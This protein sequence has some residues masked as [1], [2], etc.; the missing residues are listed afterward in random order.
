MWMRFVSIVAAAAI[1]ATAAACSSSDSKKGAPTPSTPAGSATAVPDAIDARIDAILSDGGP[2]FG[3]FSRAELRKMMTVETDTPFY[4]VN[5]IKFRQFA[6]YADGHD[7]TVSGR[8]ANNR[9][10]VLPILLEIGARPVFVADVEQELIG[11]STKWDQVAIVRYPSRKAF[12]ALLERA[13]FH[14][15]S[16][17]KDAAVEKSTVLV[18]SMRDLPPLPPVDPAT[19]SNPATAD[20]KAFTMVHLMRFKDRATDGSGKETQLSGRDAIANYEQSV[21]AAAL[22]LGIRPAAILVVEA[23]LIGDGRSW[24]EV[25]LNHFPSHGAFTALSANADWQSHQSERAGSLAD[26]YA[27]IALPIVDSIGKP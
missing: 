6:K 26:T 7:A 24:D 27:L 9:Y 2:S 13:D 21:G 17:H 3:E 1:V 11:D 14:A 19:L 12:M 10:N 25:R 4:M 18:T 16:V 23:A 8:E 15:L 22:P 20:D 5:F